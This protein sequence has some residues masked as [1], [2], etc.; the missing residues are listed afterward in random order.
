M[1]PTF[2]ERFSFAR[3]W[4]SLVRLDENDAEFGRAVGRSSTLIGDYRRSVHTPNSGVW[5]DAAE[6]LG[7]DVQWLTGK[8]SEPPADWIDRELFVSLFHRWIETA[9]KAQTSGGS[10]SD[11]G[12]ET[13]EEAIARTGI[14]EEPVGPIA[15]PTRKPSVQ[16]K[17]RQQK[18]GGEK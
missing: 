4:Q 11:R 15:K 3:W 8:R 18:R 2:G 10:R 7:V 17:P 16:G 6:R 14:A 12:P 9:R 13:A 5:P 1:T